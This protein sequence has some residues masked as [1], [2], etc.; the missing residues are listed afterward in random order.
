MNMITNPLYIL[1][2]KG[3]RMNGFG[4][5]EGKSDAEMCSILTN[6]MND[7][8]LNNPSDCIEIINRNYGSFV[9]SIYTLL[10]VFLFWK[11]I[12]M[13]F[14]YVFVIKPLKKSISLLKIQ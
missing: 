11:C 9:I 13:F 14:Y 10:L 2:R 8:W 7:I 6:T 12:T 1:Y 4:F 3:P 5:W